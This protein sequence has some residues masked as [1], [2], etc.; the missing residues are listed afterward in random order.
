L[1]YFTAIWY[2]LWPF[3]IHMLWWFGIFLPF[4]YIAPRK[5]WQPCSAKTL[6]FAVEELSRGKIISYEKN[7]SKWCLSKWMKKLALAD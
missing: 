6:H 5:T 3:G 1:V 7:T 4:L 2:F